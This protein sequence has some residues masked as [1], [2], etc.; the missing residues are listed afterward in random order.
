[1]ASQLAFQKL[2]S[3]WED[4]N[5]SCAGLSDDQLL[6]P[7]VVGKW[8]VRDILAHITTWEHEC[9]EGLAT[10]SRGERLPRYRDLYG[11]INAFNALMTERKRDLTLAEVRTQL[12]ETHA[13]LLAYLGTLPDEMLA[14]GSRGY[15]RLQVDTFGHYPEHARAIRAWREKQGL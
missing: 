8:S 5:A 13:Q 14:S 6:I 3:A 15:R 9:L 10:I 12:A 11:G 7:G 1:M 2:N 4:F